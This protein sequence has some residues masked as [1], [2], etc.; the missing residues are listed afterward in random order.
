MKWDKRSRFQK[1]YFLFL[2]FC[3]FQK[4]R[5]K[6]AFSPEDIKLGRGVSVFNFILLVLHIWVFWV[7]PSPHNNFFF[8][9]F[10]FW[11]HSWH[12]KFLRQR[13]Q[14]LPISGGILN[15]LCCMETS[16]N[17]VFQKESMRCL[18]PQFN[19]KDDEFLL[20]LSRLRPRIASMRVQVGSLASLSG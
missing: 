4:E 6:T 19:P 3:L 18:I 9:F 20:W 8:F 7:F 16:Y 14:F 13:L 1:Q 2:T 15:P 12:E 5:L 10:F 17:L 11:L